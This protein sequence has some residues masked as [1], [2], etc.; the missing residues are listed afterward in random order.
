MKS[1]ISVAD[2]IVE[3][4]PGAGTEGGELIFQGDYQDFLNCEDSVTATY[5]KDRKYFIEN[6]K[7]QTKNAP[8]LHH[9]EKLRICGARIHNLKNLSL[10]IPLYKMVGFAGVSGSGKSSLIA[11]TLV[12]KLKM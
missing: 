9:D 2:Y 6:Y 7:Q 3:L 10:S 11:H 5:L 8:I 12:P 4:G 1:I